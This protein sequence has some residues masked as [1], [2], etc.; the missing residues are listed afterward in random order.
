MV[1][2]M[3]HSVCRYVLFQFHTHYGSEDMCALNSISV[4]GVSAAQELEEAL[5]AQLDSGPTH[6]TQAQQPGPTAGSGKLPQVPAAG[7]AAPAEQPQPASSHSSGISQ[8]PHPTAPSLPKPAVVRQHPTCATAERLVSPGLLRTCDLPPRPPRHAAHPPGSSTDMVIESDEYSDEG[9]E[10]DIGTYTDSS[11]DSVGADT[12]ERPVVVTG[13]ASA[14][15]TVNVSQG[16]GNASQSHVAGAV[17][18]TGAAA[19]APQAHI[20]PPHTA[21]QTQSVPEPPGRPPVSPSTSTST[22]GQGQ[23]AHTVPEAHKAPITT[24]GAQGQ[25]AATGQPVPPVPEPVLKV[26]IPAEPALPAPTLSTS[27]TTNVNTG[28]GH[29]LPSRP[30]P[31]RPPAQGGPKT[32]PSRPPVV[33]ESPTGPVPH[34]AGATGVPAGHV[35]AGGVPTGSGPAGVPTNALPES[36]AAV[37]RVY[38]LPPPETPPPSQLDSLLHAV[39]GGSAAKPKQTGNLFDVFKQVRG[40]TYACKMCLPFI[41]R[42]RSGPSIHCSQ[43]LCT[44]HARMIR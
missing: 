32:V 19:T 35:S 13:P 17:A 7:H 37:R 40:L 27:A 16:A 24:P 21:A 3:C 10:V 23:S 39:E 26:S 12:K 5:A 11:V 4:L 43:L 6:V 18:G 28:T 15:G 31:P 34:T 29:T 14:A 2:C 25:G 20:P 44:V 36:D 8:P 38:V 33:T 42:S 41:C 22:Q 1:L 30:P 9:D